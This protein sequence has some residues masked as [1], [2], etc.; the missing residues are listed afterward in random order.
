MF[1]D[2][3]LFDADSKREAFGCLHETVS[4]SL[5]LLQTV[6]CQCAVIS[7]KKVTDQLFSSFGLGS[8]PTEVEDATIRKLLNIDAE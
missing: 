6:S 4:D 3:G 1:Y 8:W 2:L 5:G 7:I